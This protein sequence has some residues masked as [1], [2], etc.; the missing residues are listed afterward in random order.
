MWS[1]NSFKFVTDAKSEPSE[2][3]FLRLMPIAQRCCAVHLESEQMPMF[4]FG[5]EVN[6]DLLLCSKSAQNFDS[7]HAVLFLCLI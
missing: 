2:V 6:L 3:T 7:Q 5:Q 1:F 4:F